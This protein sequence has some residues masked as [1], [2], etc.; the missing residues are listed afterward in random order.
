MKKKF[1]CVMLFALCGCATWLMAFDLGPS[2]ENHVYQYQVTQTNKITKS[3]IPEGPETNKSTYTWA[4]ECNAYLWVPPK[5][6]KLNGVVIMGNNVPEQGIAGNEKFRKFCTEYDLAIMFANRSFY[7]N[8][9]IGAKNISQAE[10]DRFHVEYVQRL[11]NELSD[12][13]GFGELKNIPWIVI[14]ES[15][16]LLVVNMLTNGAPEKI[17]AGVWLKDAQFQAAKAGIPMLLASGSGAEWGFNKTDI[18]LH[19]KNKATSDANGTITTRKRI[20]DWPGSLLI[21]AGSAHFSVTDAMLEA[22][23]KYLRGACDSRLSK[24]GSNKLH[25]VNFD[26]GFVARLPG[27][28][29]K[30]PMEP[31]PYTE[32]VGEEKNLPWYFDRET[33]QAAYDLANVNWN[34]KSQIAAFTDKNGNVLPYNFNGVA[35]FVPEVEDDGISF[36]LYAKLLDE[37]PADCINAGASLEK[38]STPPKIQWLCGSAIPLGD[39]KFQFSMDRSVVNANDPGFIFKLVHEGDKDFRLCIVPAYINIPVIREGKEQKITF[40]KIDNQK[41]G[42]KEVHLKATSD[43]NL[44]VRYFVKYGPAIIQDDKLIFTDVPENSKF[45]LEVSVVAWQWGSNVEPKIKTARQVEQ[46]FHI[47]K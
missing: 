5:I 23:I 30:N 8:F 46:K 17:I 3:D 40:P 34:A 24:D 36:T 33:A 6:K 26:S 38:M 41:L 11:L 47:V 44:R 35:K 27:P 7:M 14:G 9:V 16:H 18:N 39:N 37:V 21:E 10:K 15:G 25:P 4:N 43:S 45:P 2:S 1:A 12:K 29:V 19:W 31:K 20:N 28:N 13:S 32:A 22:V 42:T